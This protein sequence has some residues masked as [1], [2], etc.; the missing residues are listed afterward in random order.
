MIGSCTKPWTWLGH[1]QRIGLDADRMCTVCAVCTLLAADE[2]DGQDALFSV[3][4][5]KSST[6]CVTNELIQKA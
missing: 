6:L 3:G 5:P 2:D 4:G 1:M